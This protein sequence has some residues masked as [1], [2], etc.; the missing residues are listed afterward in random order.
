[1]SLFKGDLRALLRNHFNQIMRIRRTVPPVPVKRLAA[2]VNVLPESCSLTSG[3]RG[4]SDSF[5]L[6][7]LA[8]T[9]ELNP[10]SLNLNLD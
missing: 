4:R 1:M 9:P 6:Q 8:V 10:D 2:A 3:R 7:A 5:Q